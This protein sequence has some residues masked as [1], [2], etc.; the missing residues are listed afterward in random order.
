MKLIIRSSSSRRGGAIILLLSAS[1]R[2][3]Y[4]GER[5][6][7]AVDALAEVVLLRAPEQVVLGLVPVERGSNVELARLPFLPLLDVAHR[8][9][10]GG[11]P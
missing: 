7:V 4:R 2:V 8:G 9:G 6:R 1:R 10:E 11:W 5:H 3:R